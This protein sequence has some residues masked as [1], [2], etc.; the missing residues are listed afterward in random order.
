MFN[1]FFF[2]DGN[3]SLIT[4]TEKLECCADI[5]NGYELTVPIRQIGSYAK[6]SFNYIRMLLFHLLLLL[7]D[8][9]I[10]AFCDELV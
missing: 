7:L 1:F 8:E 5:I 2:Y 10:T 4:S 9:C 6:N 3:N